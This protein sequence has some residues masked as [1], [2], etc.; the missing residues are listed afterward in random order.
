MPASQGDSSSRRIAIET[1]PERSALM[2]RVRQSGTSAE[3]RLRALLTAAGARYRLNVRDLPGRPDAANRSRR[4]AV[5]VHGCFW[6]GHPGC[7]K[8]GLPRSN[9]D[10]W[11]AKILGNV[12]RDHRKEVALRGAGFQVMVVWECELGS[13]TL[14]DRLRSFWFG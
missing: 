8:S 9:R 14:V 11:E 12:E 10:F 2:S 7:P 1:T 6:H 3:L 13:P 4:K 5:F